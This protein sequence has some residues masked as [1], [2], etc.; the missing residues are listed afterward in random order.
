[1]ALNSMLR[2]G[3][4]MHCETLSNPIEVLGLLG[5]GGQGEVYEVGLA[6]ERLA[7]KWYFPHV[8]QRDPQLWDRLTASI[9]CTPPSACFLWPLTLLKPARASAG[10]LAAAESFGYLMRLRPPGYVGASEHD[11][12][13]LAISLR[14]I[15]RA[16][17]FLAEAF[18]RLHN[19]G[20]CY[21]DISIGNL[22]LNPHD[23][24]ILICDN[25]NVAVTG[26]DQGASLGTAGFMAPEVLLGKAKPSTVTDL[27]SLA[28]LIFRMLT[29]SDPFKGELE[30][31]MR[32]LDVPAQRQL[33]GIDPV[34]VFDP[35]NGRNRPNPEVHRAA[36]VTWP[37]YPPDL[38]GLFQQSLG[39]G[40]RHP[41]QRVLTGQWCAVLAAVLDRRLLCDHC[42][43]EV[44]SKDGGIDRCWSCGQVPGGKRRLLLP[45]GKVFAQ[46]DN[47]LHPHHFDA[48]RLERL[49]TPVARVESHP[50][51]PHLMGLLNLG[52]QAWTVELV[53]GGQGSVAPGRHCNLTRVV[54][55]E[56]QLGSIEVGN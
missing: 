2:I 18:D 33:Y 37:I 42:G 5:R 17:Y 7:A 47:E 53:E 6:N 4:V 29:R 8:V 19:H 54:R 51:N 49:D 55:I 15:V 35:Y 27:H 26:V 23:G 41:T 56:T 34:F 22:F 39:A 9:R 40:L 32:C 20:L 11:A 1:M 44:F 13:R 45:R 38:Q 50:H 24:R 48:S 3:T 12:G 31:N 36:C 52:D 25:D 14:N 43:Q 30:M 21:K 28:V 10:R 46:P 16:C